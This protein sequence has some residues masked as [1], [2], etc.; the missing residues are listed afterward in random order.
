MLVK[1][2]EI[3]SIGFF[4]FSIFPEYTEIQS[5]THGHGGSVGMGCQCGNM[6]SSDRETQHQAR[7]HRGAGVPA[8]NGHAGVHDV[9]QKRNFEKHFGGGKKKKC[10]LASRAPARS[11]CTVQW[12]HD[13][14]EGSV[15]TAAKRYC[16]GASQRAERRRLSC[17]LYKKKG[18][19]NAGA[20]FAACY[21]NPNT[22]L[23]GSSTRLVKGC[24]G[25]MARWGGNKGKL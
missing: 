19:S 3:F 8:Y 9:R 20:S 24:K 11:M 15:H 10:L 21:H 4:L 12:V 1:E 17:P 14:G 2:T 18:H 23:W 13:S 16:R 25:W 7:R 5:P 6:V 22:W